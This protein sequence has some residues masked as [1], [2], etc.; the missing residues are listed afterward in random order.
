MTSNELR[1]RFI[2]SSLGPTR[3]TIRPER[4]PRMFTTAQRRRGSTRGS[5]ALDPAGT[6]VAMSPTPGSS[7]GPDLSSGRNREWRDVVAPP[8]D[9]LRFSLL[10]QVSP[11]RSGTAPRTGTRAAD[12]PQSHIRT[13]HRSRTT[14]VEAKERFV[15]AAQHFHFQLQQGDAEVSLTVVV[16]A[17]AEVAAVPR[18]VG[19]PIVQASTDLVL[20]VGR[21]PVRICFKATARSVVPVMSEPSVPKGARIAGLPAVP[22]RTPPRRDPVGRTP[23]VRDR[24]PGVSSAAEPASRR[25]SRSRPRTHPPPPPPQTRTSLAF[26]CVVS[27]APAVIGGRPTAP[28]RATR[29]G[30][31]L[32]SIHKRRHHLLMDD[33]ACK[34]QVVPVAHPG[35]GTSR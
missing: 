30:W 24:A 19:P 11:R 33:G 27:A 8:G 9:L 25:T 31:P 14:P 18:P 20:Q 32:Q 3:R 12:V 26:H 35:S 17:F 2:T 1:D 10:P 29:A 22:F 5:R 16:G 34:E 4:D 23:S 28:G 6:P 21:C 13:R 7:G 15:Q